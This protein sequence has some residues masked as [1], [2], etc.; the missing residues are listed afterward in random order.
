M[1][2]TKMHQLT[3]PCLWICNS[4]WTAEQICRKFNNGKFY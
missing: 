1:K 4:L 3:V 2:D